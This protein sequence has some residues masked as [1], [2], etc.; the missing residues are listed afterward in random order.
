MWIVRK[1][2]IAAS[3]LL[4]IATLTSCTSKPVA[5]AAFVHNAQ[6]SAPKWRRS[7]GGDG[8]VGR[9]NP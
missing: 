7:S 6:H 8:Q 5:H 1:T 9:V 2:L 4:I 3:A